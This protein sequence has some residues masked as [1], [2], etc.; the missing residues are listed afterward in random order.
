M[1]DR[2]SR[3]TRF[4]P[5]G[6]KG[7]TAIEK[8]HVLILGMGALGSA[9][10]ESIARAGI[11][12]LTIVDRDYV[13]YSNLQRQQLYSEEDAKLRLPKVIAAKKRLNEINSSVKINAII[14][15]ATSTSLI[16]F[17][18]GVD[19]IIDATDNFDIRL[20]LNDLT[21]KYN[22]PWI[23]GSCVGSSGMSFTILPNVTPCLHCLLQTIPAHTATCDTVGIIS[24]AVQMVAAHQTTEALKLLVEDTNSL[25]KHLLIFDLWHNQYFTMNVD[26]A[27]NVDCPSCGTTPTY[28]YLTYEAQTKSEVL[29]GR[30]TVLIRSNRKENSL[31]DLSKKLAPFGDI[32]LNPY[33]LSLTYDTYRLVFFQ[34]GRTFVHGTNSIEKA[35]NIYYGLL[36]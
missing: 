32:Q 7:Q 26:H 14:L 25:R 8:K 19:L 31:L 3:Q 30:D 29:C 34:D 9:N 1:N 27:K 23:Y 15:D 24:P 22:I 17:I 10:A 6:D 33:L 2:Y 4:K 13:E 11:G 16:P 18:K 36:G 12:T 28:P 5:I 21:Q 35:K 20:I